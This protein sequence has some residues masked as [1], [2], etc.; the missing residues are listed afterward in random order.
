MIDTMKRLLITVFTLLLLNTGA[1]AQNNLLGKID[2]PNSGAES[3]QAD[4]IEGVKFLHNFE[5]A[6]AARAFRRAQDEDPGFAMAYWV[7]VRHRFSPVCHCKAGV[8]V[9]RPAEC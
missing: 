2:F 3:A 9:L 6:D 4:F 7:V 5:Y 1:M 8:F